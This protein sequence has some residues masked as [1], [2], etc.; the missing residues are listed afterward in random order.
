MGEAC[1]VNGENMIVYRLLIG[2]PERKRP[3]ER[4]RCRWIDN[5]KMDTVEIGLCVVGLDWSGSV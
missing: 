5:I 3:L 1:N 2:K 4:P